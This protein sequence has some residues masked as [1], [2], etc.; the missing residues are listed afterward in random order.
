MHTHK[1]TENR[2]PDA[3][4]M[5]VST[6]AAVPQ[7]STLCGVKLHCSRMLMTSPLCVV[8]GISEPWCVYDGEPQFDSFLLN[9]N[10][11][12]DDV[13]CLID[14]FCRHTHVQSN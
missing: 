2:N 5:I 10:G 6:W 14:P 9:A 11:V 3:V 4:T 8:D 12:F 7:N 13:D 1:N